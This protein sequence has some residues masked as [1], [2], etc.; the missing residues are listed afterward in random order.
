MDQTFGES[1]LTVETVIESGTRVCILT[2]DALI[3]TVGARR[4]LF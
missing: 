1:G 2:P 3:Q 4:S